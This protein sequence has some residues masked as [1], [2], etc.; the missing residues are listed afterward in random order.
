MLIAIPASHLPDRP[1]SM[2]KAIRQRSDVLS[3]ALKIQR[4]VRS[5][6]DDGLVF[7]TR[8]AR[9]I[10]SRAVNRRFDARRARAGF[11]RIGVHDTRR[12]CGFPLAALDVHPRVAMRILRHTKS[13]R[14]HDR[15]LHPGPRQG[16]P[17]GAQ[18]AQ[19]CPGRCGS[20]P[21]LPG[22]DE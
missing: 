5:W 9:P 15:D 3:R 2:R 6:A 7:T 1:A 17:G 19:R 8:T 14:D 21:D 18:T 13:E 11:R 10:E 12:T 22:D 16:H 4:D 20:C